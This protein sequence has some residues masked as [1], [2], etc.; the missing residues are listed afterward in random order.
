[1][2]RNTVLATLACT[3]VAVVVLCLESLKLKRRRKELKKVF[4]F[5]KL[6]TRKSRK[7]DRRVRKLI[8]AF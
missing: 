3:L 7:T 1:M 6:F 5:L 2:L 4:W 8:K